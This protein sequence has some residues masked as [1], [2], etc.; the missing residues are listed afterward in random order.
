MAG[1]GQFRCSYCKR[2]SIYALLDVQH[3]F[4]LFGLPLCK[5]GGPDRLVVCGACQGILPGEILNVTDS[6]PIDWPPASHLQDRPRP[7]LDGERVLARW[8]FEPFWY[9]A[10]VRQRDDDRVWVHYDDGHK[11]C[12]PEEQVEPLELN[13][14]DHVFARWK[15]GA[16]YYGGE[17]TRKIGESI[18]IQYDDGDWE[19]TTLSVVRVLRDGDLKPYE[20]DSYES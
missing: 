1:H 6:Y 2:L 3:H 17:I 15:R 5:M 4:Y 7:R 19:E 8:P 10:C 18:H 9:P 14:G 16:F 12:L 20:R 13:V 11:A